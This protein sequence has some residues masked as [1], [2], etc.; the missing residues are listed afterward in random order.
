MLHW[1][2]REVGER[3]VAMGERVLVY[4][5]AGSDLVFVERDLAVELAQVWSGFDTW[6]GAGGIACTPVGRDRRSS[7]GRR[8]RRAAARGR[9]R[10]GPDSR[11]MPT[12]TGRSG[13][14]R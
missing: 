12:A 8:D 9:V 3:E 7:R 14:R 13:R 1:G 4:V 11:G 6:S 2:R 10:P 5:T